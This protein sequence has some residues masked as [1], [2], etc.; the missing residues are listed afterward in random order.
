MNHKKT[1]SWVLFMLLAVFFLSAIQ[2]ALPQ[3]SAEQL[4]EAALF[5]KEAEGD[6]QGAVQLFLKIITD[7]PENRRIAAKAQL[8]IGICYEKLGLKQ[9]Q[10][11]FQKVI[12]SY[13]EQ[14]EAVKGANEKLSLLLRAEALIRKEER[15]L[16]SERYG[17]VLAWV[18]IY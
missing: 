3:E 2:D 13:P 6:L 10:R 14:T 18:W 15:N 7:F 16:I 17:Q 9:A 4:Y 8:Q 11:A 1:F 12:D 5:K